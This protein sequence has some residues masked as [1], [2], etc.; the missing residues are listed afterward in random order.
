MG[1]RQLLHSEDVDLSKL[2]LYF[3]GLSLTTAQINY[4]HPETKW[5]FLHHFAYQGDVDL[6]TWGLQAGA[7]HAAANAAGKTP[8]H[9]AAE[10]NKPAVV[11][12][13]LNG[14]AN[15]NAKTLKGFTPLHLAVLHRHQLIVR[16]L[17]DSSVIP[18]DVNSDP[19]QGTPLGLAR[20]SEICEMLD[21]YLKHGCL[22]A[23]LVKR[24]LWH[25]KCSRAVK[26]AP[27]SKRL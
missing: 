26:L 5:T 14:G 1:K 13:L 3:K 18:V 6:V 24:I 17:L 15:P 2:R 19:V 10:A 7:D 9:L 8:L 4:T 11:L 23:G 20:D 12:T 27:G 22:K 21:E 25:A 16:V